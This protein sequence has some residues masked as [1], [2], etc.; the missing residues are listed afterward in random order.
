VD[1]YVKVD[2][3]VDSVE[4]CDTGRD[5]YRYP[6]GDVEISPDMNPTVGRTGHSD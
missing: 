1:N 2:L 5:V 4:R 3:P 6:A